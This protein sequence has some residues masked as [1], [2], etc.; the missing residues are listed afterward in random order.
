MADEELLAHMIKFQGDL[1]ARFVA[2]GASERMANALAREAVHRFFTSDL[3]RLD[4]HLAYVA[5]GQE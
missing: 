3:A 4:A 5:L 1:V 2:M